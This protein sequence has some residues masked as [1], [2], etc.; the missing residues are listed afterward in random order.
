MNKIIKKWPPTWALAVIAIVVLVVFGIWWTQRG[1]GE[2]IRVQ[3]NS[4]VTEENKPDEPVEET[5]EET[6]PVETAPAEQPEEAAPAVEEDTQ[7]TEGGEA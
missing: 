2:P 1:D 4:V 7:D 6:A 5:P 3:E